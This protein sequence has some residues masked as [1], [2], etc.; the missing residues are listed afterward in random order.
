MDPCLRTVPFLLPQGFFDLAYAEWGPPDGR[1]VVC[2]HGLTRNGR[3]FDALA[4]SLAAQGR[5]VIAVDFP[6][7]GRSAWLPEP[8]L[9]A[10]PVYLGALA[11]LL[12]RLDAPAIDWVGTS[13]G[14]IAG[15]MI[16]V[17]PRNPIARL[18]LNDVGAF[19]PEAAL[20]RIAGYVGDDPRFA[21]LAEV[22]AHLRRVAAPFGPLTDA[23]WRHLAIHGAVATPSGW[24][25]HRDP[26][27]ATAF[28]A[29]P[30]A[31]VDLWPIWERIDRDVLLIRGAQSDLLTE[32]TAAQMVQRGAA[33]VRRLDVAGCG[34]AP[35]LMAEDQIAAVA[36][37]L[38]GDAR[39]AA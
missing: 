28:L 23:Q 11:A 17:Q 26:G 29:A 20:A 30:P 34:H 39:S 25:L 7:R 37:F 6:G 2:A 16:A 32:A 22:E 4:R 19:I 3:D 33:R 14:G 21:S 5:R 1:P 31:D 27:I 9:Y 24:R 36:A 8:A 13:M 10:F 38:A 12:A 15:M 18:V 35:A